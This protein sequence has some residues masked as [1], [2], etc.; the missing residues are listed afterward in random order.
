LADEGELRDV[1]FA[2]VDDN[3]GVF[4]KAHL[5]FDGGTGVNEFGTAKVADEHGV[6]QPLAV[7]LHSFADAAQPFGFA[8]VVGDEVATAGHGYLVVNGVYSGI[9]AVRCA[10]RIPVSTQPGTVQPVVVGRGVGGDGAVDEV[11][12]GVG[13]GQGL[14]DAF[15]DL[16]G[17]DALGVAH[18]AVVPVAGE[19]GEVAVAPAPAVGGGSGVPLAA[20]VHRS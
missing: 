6:L 8:D 15:L 2:E 16:V 5:T 1:G 4:A 13:A 3:D 10:A 18:V 14:Q 20:A 11:V 12:A 9:S 19:T 17:G 7:L